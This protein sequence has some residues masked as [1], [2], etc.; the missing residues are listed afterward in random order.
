MAATM[1]WATVNR[2]AAGQQIYE[3]VNIP[4]HHNPPGI[5]LPRGLL[6]NRHGFYNLRGHSHNFVEYNLRSR[7]A[8]CR[9][10]DV[11]ADANNFKP[12]SLESIVTFFEET[13]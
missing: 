12:V 3:K 6:Y 10:F 13:I 9:Q 8:G 4:E 5:E 11:G 1:I 7:E 2:R